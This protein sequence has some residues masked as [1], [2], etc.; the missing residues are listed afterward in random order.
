MTIGAN[1]RVRVVI[2]TQPSGQGHETSFAQAIATLLCIPAESIDVVMGDTD[3][4]SVGGGSHSGRSMRHAGTVIAK[5][6]GE[7]ISKGRKIA[8][9]VLRTPADNVT[10]N[11][12]ASKGFR[13]GG[14]NDP[15][16]RDDIERKFRGNVAFG[17]WSEAQ[18]TQY[19]Q[20]ARN[21][22]EGKPDLTPYRA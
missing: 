12:Q 9:F 6:S 1:G 21:A 17:G 19:L 2:G 18:A 20:F 13:L 7:L 8:A 16:S 3:I 14:V 10:F 11:A 15:L 22:F 4:V 5:A